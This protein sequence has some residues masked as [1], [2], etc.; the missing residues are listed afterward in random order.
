MT[1][2]EALA[3][4]SR[5]SYMELLKLFPNHATLNKELDALIKD[6]AVIEHRMTDGNEF[7]LVK[8]KK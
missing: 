5:T 3:L 4:K 6:G 1:L 7:E 2:L 8:G